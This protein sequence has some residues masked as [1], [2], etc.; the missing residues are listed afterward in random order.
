[1]D[2]ASVRRA[3]AAV[4]VIFVLNGVLFGSWAAR[5]P[6]VKERL[7]VGE[8]GLGLVLAGIAIGALASMPL[9]GWWSARLGSRATTRAGLA[10]CCVVVP[11]PALVTSPY[12]AFALTLAF[13]MAMGVLDVAMNAHGV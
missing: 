2:A 5:V 4:T 12:P 8:A 13:G 9:A 1:M 11:L 3:R 6:A 10:A 7:G